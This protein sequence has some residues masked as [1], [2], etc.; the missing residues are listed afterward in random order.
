MVTI[1][2]KH[3]DGTIATYKDVVTFDFY[4]KEFCESIAGRE[5]S[6]YELRQIEDAMDNTEDV[7][8]DTVSQTITEIVR[9]NL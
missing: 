4:D 1:T 6:K 5:L 3:E 8:C 9:G 2:I 7:T